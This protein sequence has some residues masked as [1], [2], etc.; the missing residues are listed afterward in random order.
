MGQIQAVGFDMDYTLAEYVPETFDMLAYDGALAKL[1]H[2]MGYPKAALDFQYDPYA[3]MRGLVIDKK[4]G[5]LLKLDRHKYVKVAY[6][7]LNRMTS[8]ER[9]TIYAQVRCTPRSSSPQRPVRTTNQD[10]KRTPR[11]TAPDSRL[12]VLEAAPA[13]ALR[14]PTPANPPRQPA[15]ERPRPHPRPHA[16]PLRRRPPSRRLTSRPSTR[17]SCWSTRVSSASW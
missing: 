6:H 13:L 8:E 10:T 1:V 12:T 2:T 3:Y 4:R 15:R 17:P 14:Q 7:G 16:S 11:P 9:K 5:N